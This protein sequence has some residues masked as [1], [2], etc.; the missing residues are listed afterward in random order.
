[1]E[2]SQI[3]AILFENVDAEIP[4]EFQGE[5]KAHLAACRSCAM[6]SEALG[7]Q[8]QAL[9]SLP[10]LTAP[11]DFLIQIRRRLENP[12]FLSMLGQWL[13]ALFTG[14]RLLQLA[15]AVAAAMLMIVTVQVI[16]RDG[17]S[18]KVLLSQAPSSVG[19]P[20]SPGS[21]SPAEAPPASA[22]SPEYS[23]DSVTGTAKPLGTLS[24][25]AK[26]R[27]HARGGSKQVAVASKPGRASAREKSSSG[28]SGQKSFPRPAATGVLARAGG[29]FKGSPPPEVQKLFS[30]VI[31]LIERADGKVLS[32][33]DAL[34][35][36]HLRTVFAEV[37]VTNY[38]AF[39]DQLRQLGEVEFKGDKGISAS[40]DAKALV[41]VSLELR[42]GISSG[43]QLDMPGHGTGRTTISVNSHAVTDVSHDTAGPPFSDGRARPQ[44]RRT[45]VSPAP[46]TS[47]EVPPQQ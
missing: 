29:G 17:S 39:L 18:R 34:N 41:S 23:P 32:T 15:G 42:A 1:M 14:R 40:P 16:L 45:P 22:A 30:D 28:A 20:R 25:V 6:H 11:E 26:P 47:P 36:D 5:V 9:G 33:G 31:G 38:P 44:Q 21:A 19:L 2:C 37:P 12:S 24:A 8:L 43:A 46:V 4:A 13:Q 7:E 3:R 35:D 10:K 27:P